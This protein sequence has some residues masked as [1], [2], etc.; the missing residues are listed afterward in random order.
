MHCTLIHKDFE[1]NE[2]GFILV[3]LGEDLSGLVD[4]F[5][6]PARGLL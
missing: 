3:G 5:D 1:Q 4:S 2:V 6:C